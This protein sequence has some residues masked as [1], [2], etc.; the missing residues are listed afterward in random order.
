MAV[1]ITW[2]MLNSTT[3]QQPQK[4][5]KYSQTNIIVNVLYIHAL[6]FLFSCDE[7]EE[8]EDKAFKR[9]SLSL[10]PVD[11][12]NGLMTDHIGLVLLASPQANLTV[13]LLF[14]RDFGATRSLV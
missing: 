2:T 9:K 14:C 8:L 11:A 4:R 1:I 5:K 3:N 7:L 6:V 13:G 12:D 10:V